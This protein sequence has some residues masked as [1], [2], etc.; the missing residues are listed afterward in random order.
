ML[1][2]YYSVSPDSPVYEEAIMIL[3]FLKGFINIPSE[4]IPST[5]ILR[6]FIGNSYFE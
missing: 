3:N 4:D 2:H 5:S 6:K 1:N